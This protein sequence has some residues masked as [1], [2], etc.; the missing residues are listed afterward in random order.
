MTEKTWKTA[1]TTHKDG[2]PVIRGYKLTELLKKVSFTQ[3]IF[4]ILK[5]ELPNEKEEKILNAILVASIDHGVEAPS[6]TVARIT[7]GD[8]IP[9]ANSVASGIA[10]IGKH[11][12]GAV[13]ACAQLL[14][15]SVKNNATASEIVRKAKEE[16]RRLAGF[17]HKIYAVDPRT[18]AILETAKEAGFD[19][20]HI[21]IATEIEKELNAVSSKKLPLNIDGITAAV[22]SDLGFPWQLGNGF[23]VIARTVGLVAQVYEEQTRE[24][25]VS[26]RLGE[27]DVDYDGP[28]PRELP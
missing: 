14:Q 18:Q 8:G 25:P 28:S 9:M 12:G 13:E 10:A 20:P 21:L 17:G 1:I 3:S 5:G 4:L 26:H 7:A 2:I 22:I 19:G 6:A 23:F 27:E 15:E 24:K 11:H 16:S